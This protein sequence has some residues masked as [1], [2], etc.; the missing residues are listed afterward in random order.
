MYQ[1]SFLTVEEVADNLKVTRQTV[2][3]YIRSS[4]LNAVKINKN[5]RIAFK[6]FESFLNKNSTAEEPQIAYLR[7]TKNCFLEYSDKSDEFEVLYGIENGGFKDIEIN[8]DL[9]NN[10]FIFGDNFYVL[11][12]LLEKYKSRVDLIYIDP[13]FGTGQDFNSVNDDN[14]YSDRLIDSDFLEFLRKRLFLLRE[15][16]SE[17]GS[18]YLHIDKKIGHYV[19]IIMDEVFGHKNFINDIT[20]IKCN[21]KNFSRNAYGNYSDMILYYA[22]N[23]DKQI[24]NDITEP[25]SKS[26]QEQL[27]Q[28]KHDKYGSY[29]TNPIH[30]PGKTINGDTGMEWRGLMPPKGRHW[31]YS[32]EILD[33]LDKNGMIEWSATGNPRKI[34]LAKEHKGF[35][36]QDV[37]E[38]KDKGLSYVDYPTQ[39]NYDLLKRIIENSSNVNSI[40]LDCFAGS[41]S[42]LKMANTLKRQWI[43]VDN[44]NHSFNVIKDSLKKDKVLCNFYEYH[45]LT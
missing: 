38:F 40:V 3:K 26:K 4:E 15:L 37:W 11:R 5:Y 7:K 28:K 6:D 16:M 18:I 12:K 25:M 14:A 19:K 35:K 45:T 44:S 13:P 9:D 42:T 29:T 41:G 24:W 36:I 20:R 23:R 17:Q 10:K 1:S 31:R 43:G 22:K 34:V 32:R 2:S 8:H 27:F 30:A 39:K 21:P 33:E